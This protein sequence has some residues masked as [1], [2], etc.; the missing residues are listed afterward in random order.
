[1][2]MISQKTQRPL[3]G[4]E[5]LIHQVAARAGVKLDVGRSV[6]EAFTEVVREGIA[7]GHDVRLYGFGTWEVRRKA[8]RRVKSIKGGALIL[9]PTRDRVCFSVGATLSQA[10][11]G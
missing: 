8:G 9:I 6:L 2:T 5:E 4:K 11:N 7:S 10:V 3:L 1:M